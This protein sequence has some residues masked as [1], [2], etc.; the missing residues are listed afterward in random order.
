MFRLIPLILYNIL[1]VTKANIREN[2][3]DAVI[4]SNTID[5]D[6]LISNGIPKFDNFYIPS[7]DLRDNKTIRRRSDEIELT[8]DSLP[9]LMTAQIEPV[10]HQNMTQDLKEFYELNSMVS[11]IT[12][13]YY[14][15][16]REDYPNNIEK[17]KIEKMDNVALQFL[18]HSR[19]L[20]KKVITQK[21]KYRRSYRYKIGYLFNRLRRLR[22]EQLKIVTVAE[23]QVQIDKHRSSLSRQDLTSLLRF[24][25]K[26]V[27]FDIDVKDTRNWIK[28]LHKQKQ[29]IDEEKEVYI[30]KK[31]KATPRPTMAPK[32]PILL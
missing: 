12:R 10:P 9:L 2:E 28:E 30:P 18:F 14:F 11:N 27:R 20:I 22:Y 25:E 32:P 17:S 13:R 21:R 6:E 19:Y 4:T 8:V 3:P 5:I 16:D 1:R 24:Y 23:N 7:I 29:A 26:V 31:N 15:R